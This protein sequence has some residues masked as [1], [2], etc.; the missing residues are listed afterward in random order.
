MAEKIWDKNNQWTTELEILKSIIVKT[1]LVETTKWGG[2]IYTY[3]NK[4]VLG[5]GGFKSYFGV[6]FM[7]GVFLKDTHHLLV[8]AN[9]ETKA[10]RQWRMNN[11]SEI[12]EKILLDFISQSIKNEEIGLVHKPTKQDI[13]VCDF[14]E[15]ELQKDSDFEKMFRQFSKT[16]QKEFLEYIAT[17]KQEKTKISRMEKI[18]PM[19]L[20]SIGLND[21]YR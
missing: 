14:F 12:D 9:N 19:I 2:I 1:Q 7:N 6:W 11:K 3:N 20:K 16:K 13:V 15:N 4:N 5:I 17:A 21:K 10:L 8:A 18:K